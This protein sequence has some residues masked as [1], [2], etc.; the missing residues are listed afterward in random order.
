MA[1][2]SIQDIEGIEPKSAMKLKNLG[3]RTTNKLLQRAWNPKGRKAIAAET[4]IEERT[5][6]KWTNMSDLMR[7]RGVAEEYSELLCAAGVDTV[8][9]LRNRNPKNLAEKLASVNSKHSI[10]Q[11]V[12]SEKAVVRWIEHAKSLD[13]VITY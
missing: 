12:P 13:P 8:K 3:I 7:V 10:V 6:L 11:L 5:I 1:S 9:A 2:Y 4:G